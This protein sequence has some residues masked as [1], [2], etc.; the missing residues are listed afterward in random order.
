M[1]K[2]Q[3]WN[4]FWR[5]RISRRALL[6]AGAVT[7]VGAASAAVL[8]CNGGDGNGNGNGNATR[9]GSPVAAGTPRPGGAI[10]QGRLLEAQGIDPHI[11]LTGLDIDML[12][13]T[14]L[15][16]WRASVEKAILNN[17][18]TEMELPDPDGTQINFTLRKG[19]MNAPVGPAA[20]EELTST[21]CKESFI[22]RGTSISAPDRRYP[23]RFLPEK[24][25]RLETPDPYQFNI[26]LTAPFVPAIQDMANPT[27]GIVPAKV[28]DRYNSLSQVAFGSGPFMVHEFL[29][30]ERIVLK[31]NPNYFLDPRPWLD[32]I[33]MIVITEGSSLVAA[34]KAGQHD[35]N[36]A[37]LTKE[38]AEEL[39]EDGRFDVDKFPTLFYPVIHMKVIRPPFDDRR[40]LEAIDLALDRDDMINVINDGEGFYNGPIQWPQ[41]EWAL[42]QDE[43]RTFY[44]HDPERAKQLLAEALPDSDG[45]FSVRMK[46]PKLTGAT[47]VIDNAILI[48]EQLARVGI[49]VELDEVEIGTFISNTI[50]NGNFDMAFFPNLPYTEP[51]RPLSFYHSA[52]VTGTGNWTNY[53]NLELDALID[54]QAEEL[55]PEERKKI[56]LKAQRMILPEHGPQITLTGGFGY[57]ARWKHVHV[58]TT[59]T[60]LGLELTPDAGPPGADIWVDTA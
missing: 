11:D 18:V 31:R 45:R 49:D 53:T 4:R 47:I 56:I 48:K 15:Y 58:A 35:V 52:G 55:D 10:T 7:A 60:D 8:G 22:R 1:A 12:V 32:E 43:L 9:T 5:R 38:E 42:P 46:L 54:A 44:R 17:F 28:I 13:Y 30:S 21:D 59:V 26:S 2:S 39:M 6:G 50:L 34:F 16:S 3:Y 24:G 36:G 14:Y 27:W 33:K 51:D 57:S 20:G 29:G 41:A 37:I 19:V 25:G 40:V 23:Q